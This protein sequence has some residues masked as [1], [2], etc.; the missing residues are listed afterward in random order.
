MGR[1]ST[2][3]LSASPDTGQLFGVGRARASGDCLVAPAGTL[4]A[5]FAE[6]EVLP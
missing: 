5:T 2:S 1:P 4:A 3:F 6:V